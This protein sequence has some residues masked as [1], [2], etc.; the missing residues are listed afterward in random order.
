MLSDEAPTIRPT[1][2][3]IKGSLINFEE[4]EGPKSESHHEEDIESLELS[5]S[6]RVQQPWR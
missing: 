2:E 6:C 5:D 1:D 3:S 4:D